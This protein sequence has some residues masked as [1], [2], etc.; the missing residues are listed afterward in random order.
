[1]DDARSETGMLRTFLA[2]RDVSCPG[3]GYNLRG[4]A[5][6]ACPEC[7]QELVLRVNLVEPRMGAWI[8]VMSGLLAGSG[9]SLIWLLWIVM[10]WIRFGPPPSRSLPF[11][12]IPAIT[13]VVMGTAGALLA[14]PMGRRWFRGISAT[15][16][17]VLGIVVWAVLVYVA[18]WFAL[19]LN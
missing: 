16:R 18:L 2:E 19:R 15:H 9:A 13:L 17:A 10:M 6:G 5:G 3:C 7:N 12:W 4:L 8:A 1:M 14:F 11:V